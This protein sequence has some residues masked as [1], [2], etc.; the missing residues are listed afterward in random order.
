VRLIM[1]WA[2]GGEDAAAAAQFAIL[3]E[4]GG[5]MEWLNVIVNA[6]RSLFRRR[7][8]EQALNEELRFH[9]ER[10]V[11]QNL[12]A[13]MRPDEARYAALRSF[14]NAAALREET[15]EAWGLRTFDVWRQDLKYGLRMLGKNPGLAAIAILTLA[16]GIG[17][18]T[19]LFSVVN[20]VLLNPL[21][22]PHPDQLVML[23]E[24]KPNFQT[25]AIPYLNF[26]DWQR[27]NHTFSSVAL[28]R[29][30]AFSLTG[31][32]EPEQ[33]QGQWVT[34]SFFGTFGIKPVLGRDLSPSD[35]QYGAGPVVLISASFWKRKF[36]AA[37]DVL[38]RG[39]TL[40]GRSYTIIGVVPASFDLRVWND[41]TSDVYAPIRQW[42][43]PGLRNRLAAL[44]LHGI[45]RMK[46][47]VT[48]EQAEADLVRIAANLAAA[49]PDADRGTSA[50]IVPLKQSIVGDVRPF[51]LVLLGAVGLVLLIACVN[52]A[53]LL[54][55]RS[56]GRSR[57][58]AIRAAL[59]A[60]RARVIR[61]LLTESLLWAL[62]GGALGLLLAWWG[63]RAGLAALPT[64]LPRANEVSLD[65]RVLIFA[66]ALSLLSGILFGLVP[67]LK[68]SKAELH[69]MLKEGGRGSSGAHYRAHGALVVVEVALALVLLAG[70]GLMLRTLARL[71]RVDPGFNSRNVMTFGLGFPASVAKLSPA[72]IRGYVRSLDERMNSTPGVQAA[73]LF[74]GAFPILSEDDWVFWMD[75]QPK[76]RSE[77]EMDAALNYVVE[78][79]YLKVMRIP[80]ERGRFFTDSDDDHSPFVVVVDDVLASKFFPGQNPIGRRIRLE[81]DDRP[82]EIIGV[83]G[84]VKQWGLD[85]DEQNTLRAQLYQS[86]RQQV[87]GAMALLP[88]VGAGL[89]VRT[90]GSSAN[91]IDPL[92]R[93][94][95]QMNAE[96]V[97]YGFETMDQIISGSLAARRFSMILLGAF[98]ALALLLASVGIYGVTSYL[99]GQR[100]QEIGIRVALGAQ[101]RD[102]LRLV[103]GDGA[104]MALIGVA[105]G[106]AATLGLT[107]ILTRYSLLF[108]VS[109]T[110]PL[111]LLAVALLLTIVALAACYIPARR[112]LRVDP[113]V[114][115]RYE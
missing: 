81:G 72:A 91:M 99:V 101:R 80:L 19:A 58:F 97:L 11:E 7:R 20:G 28:A 92:S 57:E 63:T 8:E 75:G 100:T 109:A 16:L 70:A 106:L 6:V 18:N 105:A 9:V 77:S 54:L 73:S 41:R 1:P 33:L 88:V 42:G 15:R 69:E 95:H 107:R 108:G 112:A 25:G 10:Q 113:V 55:A 49:Y 76:P 50:N 86:L 48:L 103:I 93:S 23:H 115:L 37:P 13:G 26:L 78:P 32:G 43:H 114:A 3:P 29:G 67:A 51:L 17:A 5:S 14:G 85:S 79:E 21:P 68:T 45:G 38:G 12:A 56:A 61:Q 39:I 65:S 82:A 60:G 98:A 53:N 71:W 84:H 31:L 35:D 46:P 62:A 30:Y 102:V 47:G 96:Q 110:D 59:G 52:V 83:V 22:F 74:W 89:A 111:T 36:G 40:D 66:V 4:G 64:A 87:D 104:R 2:R 90:L 24:S 44:G 34:A 94:L 27:E